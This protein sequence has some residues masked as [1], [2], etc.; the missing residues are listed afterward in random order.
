MAA[1]YSDATDLFKFK[2]LFNGQG[3]TGESSSTTLSVDLEPNYKH[4]RA[5]E[6]RLS[7]P[8]MQPRQKP[9][10]RLIPAEDRFAETFEKNVRET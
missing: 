4:D 8:D 2:R 3:R 9:N 5:C 7:S 6:A 1:T 10:V